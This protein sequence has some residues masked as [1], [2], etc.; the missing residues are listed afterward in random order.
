MNALIKQILM[1]TVEIRAELHQLIDQVDERF[2][3]AMHLMVSTYQQENPVIGYEVDGTPVYA[4]EARKQFD[5]DLKN[6]EAFI[7]LEDFEKELETL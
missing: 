4:K 3:K 2:L 1:S 7:S 6:R 5:E